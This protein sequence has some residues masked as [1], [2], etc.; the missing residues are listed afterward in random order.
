MAI[1]VS[2]LAVILVAALLA[3]RLKINASVAPFAAAAGITLFICFLGTL[4]LFV[5]AVL[6]VY[7]LAVFSL[8]YLGWFKRKE[9]KKTV[10]TV[11]T[12]GFVFFIVVSALFII[13][14]ANKQPYFKHWD[15]FS[16]WGVAAKTTFEN[17]KLYTMF[18]S[19]MIN[20]SYPPALPVWSVFMQFCGGR[21]SEWMVYAAYDILM[22]SVMAMLFARVK[23]KNYLLWPLLSVTAVSL[24]YH[25]WYS[26]EGS[27]LY[28]NSYSDIPLG[29]LFGGALLAYFATTEEQ[30]L[31]HYAV[32][33]LGIMLLPMVK[34]VGLALGLVVWFIVS[35]DLLVGQKWPTKKVFGT[36][37][38]FGKAVYIIGL[39]AAMFLSYQIW[40][41]HLGSVIEVERN[42]V[43]YEYSIV[44][45]FTGQ[46]PYFNQVL[47]KMLDWL[48]TTMLTNFGV[49]K[50]M[51]L[52]FT[53]IPV[54][55]ALLC[56]EK[57]N[58]IRVG[59][60]AIE[61]LA[62]F[63]LYYLFQA[64]A[65]AAIFAH[66]QDV[67][68]WSF[69]RYVS[70]Y[71]IGW[72]FVI[73]GLCVFAV[74]EWRFKKLPNTLPGI[75]VCVLSL[76]SLW[77]Y[78][79]VAFDQFLLTSPKVQQPIPELRTFMIN[80]ARAFYGALDN[81]DRIYFICQGSDGGE[82]FYFNYEFMPA[83]TSQGMGGGFFIPVDTTEKIPYGKPADKA[84][85]SEFIIDD[86]I[87]YIFVQ[88]LDDYFHQEFGPM[89]S[90]NLMGF[91]DGTVYMYKVTV[92][93]DEVFCVPVY[94]AEHVEKLR[95]QYGY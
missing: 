8:V 87:D 71:P 60:V 27:Y 85:F 11:L 58:I 88:K 17:K 55:V 16:F 74:S 6:A 47:K 56:K 19:S 82:W 32:A 53:V 70:T 43:P 35:F 33:V 51:L 66:K 37:K 91:Y 78:A 1:A 46:D 93:N 54:A 20:I 22:T 59:A 67:P 50:E 90:D 64:Y 84:M 40:T 77:Y 4:N 24:T 42:A 38:W 68:L 3:V 75:A 81:D 34:D 86:G 30:S 69:E 44:Q 5:P 57:R 10:E 15:E 83:Y 28:M 31:P 26:L 72:I 23:W 49:I 45:M 79:P 21:F 62:G 80:E 76:F 9:W 52:V 92:E 18:D 41:I 29:I 25:F 39:L 7:A 65:Y 36:E 2:L 14:L 94:S 73:V 13:I 61:M 48:S 89:F 63:A 12:P 95:E